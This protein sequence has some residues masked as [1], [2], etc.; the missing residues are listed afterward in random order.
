M[1]KE[2]KHFPSSFVDHNGAMSPSDNSRVGGG[3]RMSI[4]GYP[5]EPYS[6]RK[7]ECPCRKCGHMVAVDDV[8]G[9]MTEEH[10]NS[11]VVTDV[12]G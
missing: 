11:T 1:T 7:V 10:A 3:Q 9:H 12:E 4:L 5:Y 2:A 6:Q 8:V